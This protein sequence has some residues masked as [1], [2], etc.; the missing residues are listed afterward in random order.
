VDG[1]KY[2]GKALLSSFRYDAGVCFEER[3]ADGIV[4][5]P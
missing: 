1:S 2:I 5:S 4:V 3:S